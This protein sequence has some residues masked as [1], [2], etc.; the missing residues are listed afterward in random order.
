L[1]KMYSLYGGKAL[2][3]FPVPETVEDEFFV[4]AGINSSGPTYTEIKALVNNRSGWPARTIKDLSFNYYVD[5]TEVFAAGYTA[6]DLTVSVGYQE[7]PVTISG[8]TKHSGNIYYVK[9]TF[10]DGTNIWPGGQSEYA[11]EVQFRIAAPSGTNFWSAT[12]DYSYQGLSNTAAKTKR[13][14]LYD[15]TKLLY[16]TLPDGPVPTPTTTVVPT[17]TLN[18]TPTQTVVVTPTATVTPPPTITLAPTPTVTVSPTPTQTAETGCSVSYTMNDWGSGATV[19]ITIKNNGTS[20]ING[21]TLAWAFPGNQKITNLWNGT[22]TQSGTSVTVKNMSYN[23]TIAA[24]GTV[25]FGFNI[26]YSGT[27]AK[28]TAFTLNGIPCTVN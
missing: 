24:G 12:N 19:S 23:G 8:L 10:K 7:F 25:N 13:I 16:G 9:V 2:T 1:A 11:G 3:N 18:P 6:G 5:L 28:P 27:N 20:A 26:S 4:E 22:Y 15:G 14:P 21:W 17:A